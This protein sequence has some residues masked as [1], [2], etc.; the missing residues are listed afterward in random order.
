VFLVHKLD[1]EGFNTIDANVWIV[2]GKGKRALAVREHKSGARGLDR[3]RGWSSARIARR[4]VPRTVV[5]VLLAADNVALVIDRH[6][7]GNRVVIRAVT[8]RI[9][10][11]QP[12]D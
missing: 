10:H 6:R 7:T 2:R 4:S 3:V 9:A 8:L 12:A 1:A 11:F 5:E